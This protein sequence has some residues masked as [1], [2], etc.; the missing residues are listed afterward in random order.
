MNVIHRESDYGQEIKEYMLQEK[1]RK[2]AEALAEELF[3]AEQLKR[4]KASTAK[5]SPGSAA[6]A[7]QQKHLGKMKAR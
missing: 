4:K 5:C 6:A 1:R 7:I 3:N 2:E